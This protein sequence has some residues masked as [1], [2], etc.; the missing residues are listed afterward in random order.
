MPVDFD[1]P[2]IVRLLVLL[3]V[4]EATH[5]LGT[6]ILALRPNLI[7]PVTGDIDVPNMSAGGLDIN[8]LA[9][10]AQGENTY[11]AL[12][13]KRMAG[14]NEGVQAALGRLVNRGLIEEGPAGAR[15]AKP[16]LLTEDGFDIIIRNSSYI[17]DFDS[18]AN[19]SRNH[20]PLVFGYWGGIISA[21]L[22]EWVLETL[23]KQIRGVDAAVLSQLYAGYRS[24][25][26]HEEFVNDLY[27]RIYGPW[28]EASNWEE[29][30]GNVPVERLRDFLYKNPEILK[31]RESEIEK[32]DRL[33]EN[34]LT[35]NKNYR[36][37]ISIA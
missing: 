2:L 30:S 24:R 10:I 14:S 7:Y 9:G 35:M 18:F 1:T 29:F 4:I 22:K 25:Y 33:A 11:Y 20:F 27:C 34:L 19:L 12:T 17:D 6:Q 26:T 8:V 28:P 5:Q 16:Y 32:L 31:T 3:G 15:R 23:R 13:K 36:K 21:R 37:T